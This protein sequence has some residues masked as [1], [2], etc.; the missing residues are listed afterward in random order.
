MEIDDKD[1][2]KIA[3]VLSN[4]AAAKAGLVSGDMLIKVD[5]KELGDRPMAT[6]GAAVQTGKPVE[7]EIERNGRRSKLT[8]R[9]M[10]R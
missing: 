3:E 6:L 2:V 5:G 4:G 9:P 8:V 10:P 1:R 7:L